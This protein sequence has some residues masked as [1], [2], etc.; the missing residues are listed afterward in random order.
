MWLREFGA[1]IDK[2]YASVK[3]TASNLVGSVKL[4]I[5]LAFESFY[6]FAVPKSPEKSSGTF[7][8]GFYGARRSLI[9]FA[10]DGVLVVD[11]V[12][13]DLRLLRAINGGFPSDDFEGRCYNAN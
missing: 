4:T 10:T 5:T 9:S 1:G 8:S 6:V 13:G 2:I 12:T 7:D 3:A 11:F